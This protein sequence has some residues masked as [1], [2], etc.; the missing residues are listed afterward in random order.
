MEN[1]MDTYY[2]VTKF[3]HGNLHIDREYPYDFKKLTKDI[4]DLTDENKIICPYDKVELKETP[5]TVHG[6]SLVFSELLSDDFIIIK[7]SN[8][9]YDKS[10][11][12]EL[13]IGTDENID[14]DK[15]KIGLCEDQYGESPVLNLP[16]E[17]T[18]NNET[19][20][21]I[22]K[23]NNNTSTLSFLIFK[24]NKIDVTS[25]VLTNINSITINLNQEIQV[26][27]ISDIV[28]KNKKS[29]FT[30]EDIDEQLVEA[31]NHL[32]N[33]LKFSLSEDI[34]EEL[35]YLLPKCVAAFLYR[36]R[37]QSE[38]NSKS[39]KNYSKNYSQQ[40]LSEI[41]DSIKKY[42]QNNIDNTIKPFGVSFTL[43]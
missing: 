13:K 28:F 2:E 39:E 26:L 36:I 17:N 15:I 33:L 14:Y 31:E 24:N 3:L 6:K 11:T 27:N 4:G 34:P 7:I 20:L 32:K 41:E 1:S 30:L 38:N 12:F 5:K 42:E 10:N 21:K 43:R 19:S 16:L 18:K 9:K 37:W 40:L 8:C 35:E 22:V 29:A 25:K 23:G